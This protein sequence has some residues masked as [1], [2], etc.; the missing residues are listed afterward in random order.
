MKKARVIL[1]GLLMLVS[2]A[3]TAV[4]QDAG[5]AD[6]VR[7]GQVDTDAGMSVGVPV[8]AFNDAN[9]GGY[10]LGFHWNSGDITYDSISYVGTRLPSGGT[11]LFLSDVANNRVLIGYVDFSAS[12]PITS[13]DGLL[14]TLWFTVAGGAPDQFV[15]IDSA[16]VPPSGSFEFSPAA[17]VKFTPQ[18]VPGEIKIGDPQPPPVI[19]LSQNT[20]NFAGLVGMSNPPT[21][22]L[23]ITNGGGQTLSWSTTQQSSWLGIS[24]GA[25]TAPSNVV[26]SVNTSGLMAGI[27]TDSV[28]VS[29]AGAT[30]S[31]QLVVVNLEMTIP[32]P[33]I[34]LSTD[35]L[36]FQGLQNDANPP[37]QSF[38]ITNGAVGTVLNWTATETETWLDLDATSGTAPSTVTVSI[39]N[40]GLTAGVYS[41][42]IEISDPTASNDPQF[43]TVVFEVFSAFPVIDPI[44]DS[45]YV[46]GSGTIDPVSRMLTIENDGGGVLSWS[47]TKKKSWLTVSADTGSAVQGSPS[48]ITLS[49]NRNLVNFGLNFDTL[50]ISAGSAINS[51]VRVPVTFWKMENPQILYANPMSLSFVETECGSYP[52][53]QPKNISISTAYTS[54]QVPWTISFNEPWLEVSAT[55]GINA[56]LVSVSVDVSGLSAGVYLDTLTIATDVSLY[57]VRKIPVTFTVNPTPAVK[58]LKLSVDSLLYLFK[59]TQLGTSNQT[60]TAYNQGGGCL[61]FTATAS[62]PWLTPSPNNSTTT[63]QVGIL[64]NSVGLP[65]G[66]NHAEVVF[67][68]PDAINSPVTL[69]VTVWVWTFG[70]ANGNG[71]ISVADC[72]YIINYIFGGG[73]APIPIFIAGDVNCDRQISIADCV[74]L[75]N[76]IFGG[77]PAPCLY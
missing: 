53:V 77:G 37:D 8:T 35:S 76:Y 28:L 59:Y 16:F 39:D 42:D 71:Y 14:F 17:G 70:D 52:G 34:V 55:S 30:N 60:I 74:Y 22:S 21:Q 40:T 10:S 36:Y 31:P 12:F 58:Q 62:V 20:Y 67:T 24:P 57:P 64:A 69:P 13:G 47:L 3:G 51:P 11:K 38:N 33:L 41:T 72:V 50:V 45:I 5:A 54:P 27:Y 44:P 26:L 19:V 4:A 23:N 48:T 6:T 15:A 46:I 9:I 29:A 32:P 61:D 49:F 2:I 25:G 43:V 73:P 7:A 68:A 75:L 1:I 65:L 66:P 56:A 63:Q 18:Y